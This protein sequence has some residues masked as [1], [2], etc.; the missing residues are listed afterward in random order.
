M[1]TR[2]AAAGL[3]LVLAGCGHDSEPAAPAGPAD[4]SPSPYTP[5]QTLFKDG[6]PAPAARPGNGLSC[7]I[8]EHVLIGVVGTRCRDGSL[9][10]GS[11]EKGNTGWGFAGQPWH[12]GDFHIDTPAYSAAFTKCL[13]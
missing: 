7:A 9:L 1:R 11:H 4:S 6:Q 5:C 10:W 12:A 2:I 3:L 8:S 13:G